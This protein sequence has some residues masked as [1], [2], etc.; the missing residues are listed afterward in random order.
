MT[1][2]IEQLSDDRLSEHLRRESRRLAKLDRLSVTVRPESWM[3]CEARGVGREAGCS[4]GITGTCFERRARGACKYEF[5]VGW[6]AI[7]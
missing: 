1:K 7:S 6:K 2:T 3:T 5:G 4:I